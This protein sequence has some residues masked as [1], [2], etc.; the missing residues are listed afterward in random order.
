MVYADYVYYAEVFRGAA[1][2]S[3][4]LFDSLSVKATAYIRKITFGRS[5][6]AFEDMENDIKNAMCAVCEIY[7]NTMGSEGIKSESNDGYSVTYADT[8]TN[9]TSLLNAAKLYLP[10]ELL[11]RGFD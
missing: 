4:A 5:D 1:I 9:E 8:A 2:P 10:C 11:Y 3:A 6:K 7:Y